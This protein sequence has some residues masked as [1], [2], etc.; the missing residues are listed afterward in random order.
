MVGLVLRRHGPQGDRP[1]GRELHGVVHQVQEDLPQPD[2]VAPAVRDHARLAVG[3]ELD[4][5]AAGAV[6]HQHRHLVDQV[7]EVEV[8]LLEV[9]ALG[10]DLGEVEEAVDQA[11][12]A[13]GRGGDAHRQLLLVLIEVGVEEQAGQP[14]HRVHRGPDLVGHVGEEVGLQGR[15]VDGLVPGQAQ[16][17]GERLVLGDDRHVEQ[18]G[19]GQHAD[20]D[21]PQLHRHRL[22]GDL[23]ERG[24]DHDQDRQ[25]RGRQQEEARAVHLGPGPVLTGLPGAGARDRDGQE[26]QRD[27]QPDH[28]GAGGRG[29]TD[30]AGGGGERRQRADARQEQHAPAGQ[31]REL[32]HHE[33]HHAQQ[34]DVTQRI[35][36]QR[37]LV[38]GGA[39]GAGVEGGGQDG[40]PAGEQHAGGDHQVLGQEPQAGHPALGRLHQRQQGQRERDHGADGGQVGEGEVH[41]GAPGALPQRLGLGA[42]APQDAAEGDEGPGDPHPAGGL[43]GDGDG[44]AGGHRGDQHTR[45][46]L[47]PAAQLQAE[48]HHEDRRH[49]PDPAEPP[50]H[51]LDRR[52]QPVDEEVE[53]IGRVEVRPVLEVPFRSQRSGRPPARRKGPLHPVLIGHGRWYLNHQRCD[54]RSWAERLP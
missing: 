51:R 8:D 48:E 12:Q 23:A 10:L 37:D 2:R 53:A 33:H 19:Q 50:P 30:L 28:A 54:F 16:L 41:G 32:A 35:G 42:A 6:A 45:R 46:P 18:H 47:G 31:V 36:H 49:E 38:Q 17:R 11:E 25:A 52:G 20:G 27:G 15:C 22:T 7:G 4:L 1:F 44:D 5:L 21:P 29:G 3:V 14:D 24:A 39:P 13:L 40:D 43:P 26:R 9:H 34:Q